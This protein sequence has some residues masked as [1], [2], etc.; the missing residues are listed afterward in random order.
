MKHLMT[1]DLRL[2]LFAFS[3]VF[4]IITDVRNRIGL[5]FVKFLKIFKIK[6]LLLMILVPW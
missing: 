6:S 1:L 4:I 3:V 2:F 5:L